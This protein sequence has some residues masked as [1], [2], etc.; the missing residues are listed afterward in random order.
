MSGLK[1]MRIRAGVTQKQAAEA[2]GVTVQSISG[3]ERGKR[4]IN[5]FDAI[6]LADLYGCTL[7]E[8]AGRQFPKDADEL[9]S[10]ERHVIDAMRSTDERGRGTIVAIAE[11]QPGDER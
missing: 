10:D 7:D 11:A 5:F 4:E 2:L 6:K 8:L 3:Y 1:E 9:T